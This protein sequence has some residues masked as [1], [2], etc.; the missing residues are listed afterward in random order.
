MSVLASA[1]ILGLAGFAFAALLL[2]NAQQTQDDL[3]SR[4]AR[5]DRLLPQTQCGQ[6][7]FPGCAPYAKAIAQ[8]SADINQCPPG[9]ERGVRA[10]ADLLGREPKPINPD[11]GIAPQTRVV[12]RI[13]EALCIGCTLC[14]RA[15]PVDAIL[16]AEKLMHT[17]ITAE[18]TGCELCLPPCPV[19]CIVMEAAFDLPSQVSERVPSLPCIRCGDCAETCPVQLQ[20]QM[21]FQHALAR[22]LRRAADWRLFDC[23]ECGL[24]ETV[25]PSRIPLLATYRQSKAELRERQAER[26]RADLS[27]RRHGARQQREDETAQRKEREREQRKAALEASGADPVAAAIARAKAR[28]AAMATPPRDTS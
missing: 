13:E 23:I 1:L 8:G 22:D 10:L 26:E 24:C 16:G 7:G 5:I 12:A 3:D 4:I 21:I 20:P 6:C 18:C 2:Q 27:R 25:C 9:G 14:I 15:C 19:D 28:K 11:N 17:V